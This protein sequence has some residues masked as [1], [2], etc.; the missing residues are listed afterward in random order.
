MLRI[1]YCN[2]CSERK[3]EN[4]IRR[5]GYC[6]SCYRNQSQRIM[7]R[8]C[9]VPGWTSISRSG[10]EYDY[11]YT[12]YSYSDPEPE[13]K[14]EKIKISLQ[15]WLDKKYPTDLEKGKLRKIDIKIIQEQEKDYILEGGELDVSKYSNLVNIANWKKLTQP[16]MVRF[17]G[18]LI[19]PKHYENLKKKEL[20]EKELEFKIEQPL[21]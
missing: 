8:E 4:E 16:L 7:E 17:E 10:E 14:K 1:K 5:D 2:G 21:K 6:F 3:T 12:S 18:N 11:I 19:H 9:R 15:S 20:R 13:P